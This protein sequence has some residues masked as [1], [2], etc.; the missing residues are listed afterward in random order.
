M[1]DILL[2]LCRMLLGVLGIS[3]VSACGD[4]GDGLVPA[5]EYG[6]PHADYIVSG[7]VTDESG[8]P[9]RGIAVTA[10]E[11]WPKDT[12]YTS[13]DGSYEL[14][15]EFL[16]RAEIEVKYF[17]VDKGENGGWYITTQ[18]SVSL[19]QQ[20]EGDGRWYDGV[21][22]AFGVDVSMVNGEVTPEYGTPYA[23]YENK[24]KAGM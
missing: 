1:K 17:D 7:K 10:P 18:K 4:G 8:R 6:V 12:V 15:G 19:K 9:V 24:D 16:P 11:E 5:P 23:S 2:N 13:S 3:A 20:E 14:R 22:A 21:F